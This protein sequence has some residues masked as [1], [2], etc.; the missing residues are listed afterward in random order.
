MLDLRPEAMSREIGAFS[1]RLRA[2]ENEMQERGRLSKTDRT[3]LN[4]VQQ[5]KERLEAKFSNA[6]RSGSWDAIQTAFA[7]DW[8]SLVVEVSALESRLY[9]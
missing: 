4:Q 2:L 7:E 9:E 8:N 3:L 6:E 1:Q 5:H